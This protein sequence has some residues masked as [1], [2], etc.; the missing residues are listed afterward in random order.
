MRREPCEIPNGCVVISEH[1]IRRT[2]QGL[3]F[4]VRMEGAARRRFWVLR[5]EVTNCRYGNSKKSNYLRYLAPFWGFISSCD[6]AGEYISAFVF[7]DVLW[8]TIEW[9]LRIESWGVC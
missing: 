7:S 9:A 2:R 8:F 6:L 3:F 4:A 5:V 1:P